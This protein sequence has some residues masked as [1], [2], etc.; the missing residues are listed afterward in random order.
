[1]ELK[2]NVNITYGIHVDIPWCSGL[3]LLFRNGFVIAIN[4]FKLLRSVADYRLLI[5]IGTTIT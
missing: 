1:M 3:P 5:I 4:N 2:E